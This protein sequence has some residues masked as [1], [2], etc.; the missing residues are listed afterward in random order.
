MS[1]RV[2]SISQLHEIV[3]RFD[4]R[5]AIYRGEPNSTFSLVP[6]IA[7]LNPLLGSVRAGEIEAFEKFKNRAT[8]MLEV[9]PADDW[10]W[11][12]LAQHHGLPTRLLDWTRNPLVAAFFATVGSED[13]DRVIWVIP[14]QLRV[15]GRRTHL[16]PFTIRRVLKLFPRALSRRVQAQ[17]AMFTAHPP[18]FTACDKTLPVKRILID[19][20]AVAVWQRQ[21]SLYG[22]NYESL[23]PDLDGLARHITWMRYTDRRGT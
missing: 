14:D 18:P 16:N 17:Q 3:T 12:T 8:S 23:F 7:R 10:D 11:L 5:Y 20:E 21:L 15:V 22:M 13:A 6:R 9:V 4:P 19:K 1:H 2:T